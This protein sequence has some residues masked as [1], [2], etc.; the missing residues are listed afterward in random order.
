[1]QNVYPQKVR[2]IQYNVGQIVCW[3]AQYFNIPDIPKQLNN[4]N[5]NN[6][7]IMMFHDW[8]GRE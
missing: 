6:S 1:M 2:A 5:N 7:I 8:S 3:L 4:N